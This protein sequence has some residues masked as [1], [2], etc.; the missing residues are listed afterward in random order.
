MDSSAKPS[1]HPDHPLLGRPVSGQIATGNATEPGTTLNSEDGGGRRN[2]RHAASGDAHY[3]RVVIGYSMPDINHLLLFVAAALLLAIAAGPGIF[4][5]ASRALAGGRREGLVSSFGTGVGGIV[6]V[7]AG[8]LG[9]SALVLSSAELF[10]VLKLVGAAYLAWLGLRTLLVAQ[11]GARAAAAGQEGLR[12]LGSRHALREGVLVE[13]SNPKTAAFFLAFIPQFVDPV[14]GR[15]AVQFAVLGAISVALNTLA[16][17]AVSF[18]A[19]A[20]RL[21]AAANP[22]L[23]RRLRETSGVAMIALGVGVLVTERPSR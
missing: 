12:R 15:V 23:V 13:G 1:S 22:N 18:A 10:A 2:R 11:S 5:V 17:I 9:I 6:H 7:C 16:D 21:G 8:A 3:D 19:S 20:V 4:Y 14:A